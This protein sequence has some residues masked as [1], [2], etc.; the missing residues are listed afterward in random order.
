MINF[1]NGTGVIVSAPYSLQLA[2]GWPNTNYVHMLGTVSW[3][4]MEVATFYN[5]GDLAP[6]QQL[7][8][9]LN[10]GANDAKKAKVDGDKDT[11][12]T[13]GVGSVL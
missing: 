5:V 4:T 8:D 11:T 7:V 13:A 10:T 9:L 1:K 2:K 12:Q 6:I 3:G